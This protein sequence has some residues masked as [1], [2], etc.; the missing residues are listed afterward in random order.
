MI[1]LL[2]TSFIFVCFVLFCILFCSG[3]LS[4]FNVLHPSLCEIGLPVVRQTLT[5]SALIASTPGT[6]KGV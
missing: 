3:G 6:G 5:P 4:E 1:L 2:L